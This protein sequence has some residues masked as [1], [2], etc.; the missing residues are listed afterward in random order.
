MTVIAW[1]GQTLAADRRSVRHNT[2]HSL[3]KIKRIELQ[4]RVYLIGASGDADVAEAL[5]HWFESGYFSKDFPES[6]KGES[7]KSTLIA[8]P[9][10]GSIMI[11]E[12]TPYPI[13]YPPQRFAIGSGAD[14]AIAAMYVG[15]TAED[16]V[17]VACQFDAFCGEGVTMLR[18]KG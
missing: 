11:F 17:D 5:K 6:A 9:D 12:R 3:D 10:D 7:L 14:F 18:H 1:D 4:G 15:K 13:K 8:V 16:A 2:I